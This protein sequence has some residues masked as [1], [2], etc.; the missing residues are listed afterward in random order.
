[1]AFLAEDGTGLEAANSYTDRTFA[2]AF[3][4]DR[5]NAAWTGSSAVKE[6]ALIKATDY[7]ESRFARRFIGTKLTQAQ[8]LSWPREDAVDGDGYTLA[9]DEVPSRIQR[10]CCL[11]A[12]RAL[13][14]T[15]MPDPT[16]DTA[17]IKS[18]RDKIG[19]IETETEYRSGSAG[20]TQLVS[21]ENI[22]EY[23]EADLLIEP[24]LKRGGSLVRA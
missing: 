8:A 16:T 5:S 12:V 20:G 24:L 9:D 2:D 14:A 18:Q 22:P 15:L 10:A 7:I 4:T 23:P 6:V 21:G 17:S 11:Y 19:P 1:M 3:F 13:T